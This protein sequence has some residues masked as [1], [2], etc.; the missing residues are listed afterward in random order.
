MKFVFVFCLLLTG[1]GLSAKACS[2][3]TG[4]LTYTCSK[5]N[6]EYVQNDSG[7]ALHVD[8]NGHPV[9]CK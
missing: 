9:P 3:L 4:D 5:S 1:C 6:V 8:G 2:L 7:I